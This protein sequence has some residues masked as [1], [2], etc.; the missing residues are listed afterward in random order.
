[1]IHAQCSISPIGP[2][3]V[4]V[5]AL[6]DHPWGTLDR[7]HLLIVE[8]VDD[9]MERRLLARV[10][11]GERHPVITLPYATRNQQ[12]LVT[13][14][15]QRVDMDS[16][17]DRADMLSRTFEKPILRPDDYERIDTTVTP[18]TGIL[19]SLWSGVVAAWNWMVA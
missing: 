15:T 2:G 5:L 3:D 10:K 12:R 13:R 11:A 19:G 17:I 7:K 6:P 9:V 8:W 16:V 18:S 1:M 14:S 4:L